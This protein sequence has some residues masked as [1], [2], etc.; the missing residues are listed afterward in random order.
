VLHW[1]CLDIYLRKQIKNQKKINHEKNY[2]NV[3]S[4][5][6]AKHRGC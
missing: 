4:H 2:C 6:I 3:C 1:I 5:R